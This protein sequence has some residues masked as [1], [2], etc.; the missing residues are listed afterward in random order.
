MNKLIHFTI[1]LILT[2]I[3]LVI[4]INPTLVVDSVI[5]TTIIFFKTLF[6]ILFPFLIVTYFLI[7]LNLLIKI[8]DKLSN[9]FKI[10]KIKTYIFIL[11]LLTGYPNNAKYINDLYI[12]NIINEKEANDLLNSS[13]FP[14]PIYLIATIGS[15]Y[16][17]N[18]YLSIIILLSFILTNII[19]F[20]NIKINNNSFK[21][22][23]EKNKN[24]FSSS[25]NNTINTLLIIMGS[26]VI[27]T[28]LINIISYYIKMPNILII[29][30]NSILEMS[31]SIIR[32]TSLNNHLLKILLISLTLSFSGLSMIFQMISLS[33]FKINI[34]NLIKKRI[35]ALIINLIITL[36][37]II[38]T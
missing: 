38:L 21:I 25:I 6:P 2:L 15:I 18:I 23:E 14:S 35:K 8:I 16:L 17:K 4:L 5:N 20:K 13:F 19:L 36:I 27:F 7:H 34:K 9:I 1:L 3:I 22:K 11:S 10:N 30:I 24:I 31:S 37:L 12:E 32:I 29:L 26:I 28:L 33:S